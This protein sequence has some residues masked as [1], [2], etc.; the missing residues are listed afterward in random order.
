MRNI[1]TL[2]RVVI[3]LA[4]TLFGML[5]NVFSNWVSSTGG[6]ILT[7]LF[8][9]VPISGIIAVIYMARSSR[10]T[11][12]M[13]QATAMRQPPDKLRNARKGMIA[14]VS[15]YNPIKDTK[16][17][18]LPK[19]E[20]E[21]RMAELRQAAI[22]SDY[23]RLNLEQSN[24]EPLIKAITDHQSRLQHCWL[25]ATAGEQGSQVYV[26]ALVKY[27]REQKGIKERQGDQGCEFHFGE[28]Y[29]ISVDKRSETEVVEATRKL[30][31]SIFS[32]AHGE[33]IRLGDN[34]IIADITSGPRSMPL[35]MILACLD[36]QRDIEFTG[37]EYDAVVTPTGEL[38]PMIFNFEP[39]FV[40]DN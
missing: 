32:E 10:V 33:G 15:L 14:F 5:V 31:E 36:R 39:R 7:F 27:L 23:S 2:D 1:L 17:R 20:R 29:Q 26:P 8:M 13:S 21:A 37:T 24:L 6:W 3:F 34:E 11:V 38:V 22:Q 4:S 12:R 28:Q 18:D 40:K 25:I 35:G 30:V 16:F 19:Q 9:A